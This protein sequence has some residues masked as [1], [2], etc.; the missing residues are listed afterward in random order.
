M[1]KIIKINKADFDLVKNIKDN[2]T[3]VLG[4]HLLENKRTPRCFLSFLEKNNLTNNFNFFFDFGNHKEKTGKLIIGAF[5]DELYGNDYKRDDLYYS[6]A[7]K[8]Y[9]FYNIRFNKIY[10]ENNI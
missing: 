9:Y 7:I 8:G 10:V 4:L 5:L 1:K 6:T 2:I 3:G